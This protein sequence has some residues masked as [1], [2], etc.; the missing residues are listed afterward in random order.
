MLLTP[1]LLTSLVEEA[2]EVVSLPPS[3]E[4]IHP[5]EDQLVVV[6]LANT[7]SSS[8]TDTHSTAAAAA[9]EVEQPCVRYLM[10]P[11]HQEEFEAALQQGLRVVPLKGLELNS[12]RRILGCPCVSVE[13]L[14]WRSQEKGCW[15]NEP[16]PLECDSSADRYALADER[17]GGG[18]ACSARGRWV[19][20]SAPP[21][22]Q[23]LH[24]VAVQ[25]KSQLASTCVSFLTTAVSLQLQG[26]S[27]LQLYK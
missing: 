24:P 14:T 4:V 11:Q 12:S 1:D 17:P 25:P 8:I 13:E 26:Q 23:H 5:T 16:A 3:A 2:P 10:L 27:P 19:C 21:V 9:A 6:Y 22:G 15:G 18:A 20:R 7:T